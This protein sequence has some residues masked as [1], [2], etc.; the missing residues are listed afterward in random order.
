MRLL[1]FF[2]I[3][4]NR[5]ELTTADRLRR[6]MRDVPVAYRQTQPAHRWKLRAVFRRKGQAA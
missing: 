2:P 5:V 6:L 1:R 3:A 4:F